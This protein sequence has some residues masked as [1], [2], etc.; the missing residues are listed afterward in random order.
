M[1]RIVTVVGSIAVSWLAGEVLLLLSGIN[2]DYRHPAASELIPRSGGPYEMAPCGHVPFATVRIRYPTNPRGYFNANNAVDH[3]M[4]SVG[5]RDD[6]HRLS[7]PDGTYRILGL[8]DSYLFGQGV[9]T[10]DR[11]LD[12]LGELLRKQY[13]LR[14]V[15]TI[16][17]GQLAYNTVMESRVLKSCGLEYQPNL[18][19]LH[20]VPNDVEADVYTKQA[21][22]EFFTE[23]MTGSLATDWMSQH[24]EIWAL[25][26]RAIGGRLRGQ[27]YIRDSI[28]SFT[29]DPEKW[30]TCRRAL[31]DIVQACRV[32]DIKLL[33]VAFP[34]F[35][36]LN[37]QYPFQPIHDRLREYCDG[38]GV[39]FIDLRDHYRNYSGP[40]LWVHP[41]DQ[42]PNE[43]AHRI[44]AEAI[45]KFLVDHSE[46]F[47]LHIEAE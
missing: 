16:N 20:F 27:S 7:K 2:N 4:N 17:A 22:V 5:W 41:T 31:E 29:S 30:N 26:H 25:F 45:A 3:T 14:I 19:I 23:Y 40:E 21:K 36:H 43:A 34:F 42:H 12:R 1:F 46:L 24:S 15:E 33:I 10:Q 11:C 9:K 47:R 28:G 37:S 35:Y 32:H 18:V 8:G 44:A 38:A 39:S 13:P 6:E